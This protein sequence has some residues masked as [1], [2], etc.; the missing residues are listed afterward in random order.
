VHLTSLTCTPSVSIA[1][2]NKT[3]EDWGF[4]ALC[5][6]HEIWYVRADVF[7]RIK[8]SFTQITLNTKYQG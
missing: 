5:F 6:G 4:Y 2:A 7:V 1:Q 8:T 3:V